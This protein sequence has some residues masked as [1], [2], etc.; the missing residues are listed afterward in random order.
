M[1]IAAIPTYEGNFLLASQGNALVRVPF[2]ASRRKPGMP[3][4]VKSRQT[5]T[6]MDTDCLRGK[7]R[8]RYFR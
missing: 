8:D 5:A 2:D 7:V 6:D 3:V 4:Y 1:Y